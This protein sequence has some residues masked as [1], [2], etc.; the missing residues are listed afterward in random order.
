MPVSR[1]ISKTLGSVLA[2][3]LASVTYLSTSPA[4]ANAANT[5]TDNTAPASDASG[6][7]WISYF[8]SLGGLGPVLRNATFEADESLHVRYLANHSLSCENNVHD[9]LTSRVGGCGANPYATAAG[10]AA[11]LNSNVT[12]VNAAI[13]DRT[14]VS[15]WFVSAFHALTLLEPRLRSTGYAAYYT[16]NPTGARPNAYQ[17]T[18]SVDVYRGRSGGYGGQTLAFPANGAASPLLSYQI[19]TE[20]PEPFRS[21]L[22]SSA[23]H[24]WG[25]KSVVSAPIVMQWPLGSRAVQTGASIIDLTTGSALPTCGL[26]ASQYPA[27]SLAS[28]FLLGT[29]RVT[30]AAFYYASTPFVAGHRY[31]LKI[32]GAPATTFSATDLPSLP[33]LTPTALSRGI[34]FTG[35]WYF[36]VRAK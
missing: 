15:N 30:K 22:A 6:Y 10:R 34:L 4:Q 5:A 24:S 19:G 36:A 33:A 27:G 20:S 14:A 23:C 29:N 16:P 18:A 3:V 12:R 21:T 31:Q 11:A 32:A 13:S 1:K 17:F 28:Q 7:T 35:R 2:L 25:A 26:T 9:E 8:R